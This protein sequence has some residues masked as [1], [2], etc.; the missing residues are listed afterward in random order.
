[1][2]WLVLQALFMSANVLPVPSNTT[3]AVS[4]INKGLFIATSLLLRAPEPSPSIG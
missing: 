1:V 2:W 3:A 4:I